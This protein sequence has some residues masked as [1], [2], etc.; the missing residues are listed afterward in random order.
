MKLVQLSKFY[1]C[2]YS[3]LQAVS[4]GS[5]ESIEETQNLTGEAVSE[6]PLDF[7]VSLTDSEEQKEKVLAVYMYLIFHS[8]SANIKTF[9]SKRT[10]I[11]KAL[12]P[13]AIT[14]ECQSFCCKF[15][16]KNFI[17]ACFCYFI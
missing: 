11:L 8:R 1:I 17:F 15:S 4:F 2:L 9:I 5:S 6:S 14:C 13:F 16:C 3:R 7:Y 12:R 10:E